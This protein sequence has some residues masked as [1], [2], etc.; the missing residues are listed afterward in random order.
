[1]NA[2]NANAGVVTYYGQGTG[3]FENLQVYNWEQFKAH[4]LAGE[5]ATGLKS[6]QG[7]WQWRT[8]RSGKAAG[9]LIGGY[10]GNFA[11]LMHS[12]YLGFDPKQQYILF[13]EDY[14]AFNQVIEVSALLSQIEQSAIITRVTG[15][16]F[17]HYSWNVPQDLLRRLTRFGEKYDVPVVYM[18]DFG[19]ETRNSILPIGVRAELDADKQTLRFL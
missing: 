2:V 10:T 9:L 8:L 5:Q 4:F 7:K 12:E 16:V 18:D 13:L 1:L 3:E 19:H 6:G 17:G 14:E 15:L 11:W